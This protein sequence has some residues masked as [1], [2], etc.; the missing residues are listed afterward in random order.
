MRHANPAATC[1]QCD[2]A[3]ISVA[4]HLLHALQGVGSEKG[5]HP[6]PIVRRII[7]EVDKRSFAQP[8]RMISE[9]LFAQQRDGFKCYSA[10]FHE[11]SGKSILRMSGLRFLGKHRLLEA[12]ADE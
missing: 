4:R 8:E 5:E 9:D 12:T 1:A 7:G 2:G 11:R 10:A 3:Q 6:A